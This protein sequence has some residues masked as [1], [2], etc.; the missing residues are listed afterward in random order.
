MFDLSDLSWL[1]LYS[2]NFHQ[3]SMFFIDRSFFFPAW[4]AP[5]FPPT[6]NHGESLALG[7]QHLQAAAATAV[8]RLV[9]RRRRRSKIAG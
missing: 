4:K 3:F 6:G 2:P 7:L 5:R 8:R 1:M 9:L